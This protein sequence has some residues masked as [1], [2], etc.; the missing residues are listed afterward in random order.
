[1]AFCTKCGGKLVRGA[2]FCHVCGNARL[3]VEAAPQEASVAE[4]QMGSRLSL[5]V[6]KIRAGGFGAARR[7]EEMMLFPIQHLQDLTKNM[8]DECSRLA[9]ALSGMKV[10]VA[11]LEKK[12]QNP[13]TEEQKILKEVLGKMQTLVDVTRPRSGQDVFHMMRLV[14]SLLLSVYTA[15]HTLKNP[16]SLFTTLDLLLKESRA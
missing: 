12:L 14:V 8:F 7:S 10:W 2:M 16:E 15:V 9:D 1:M 13:T 3:S 4:A 6:N 11:A 5:L